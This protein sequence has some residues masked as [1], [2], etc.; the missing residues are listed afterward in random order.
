VLLLPN[1]SPPFAIEKKRK[2]CTK[3]FSREKKDFF[4]QPTLKKKPGN[5]RGAAE[6][7]GKP[8]VSNF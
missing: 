5:D 2:K 3:C 4:L 8:N 6:Q 1:Y 7:K